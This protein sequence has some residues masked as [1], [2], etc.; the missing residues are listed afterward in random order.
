MIPEQAQDIRDMGIHADTYGT[1]R[2]FIAIDP[3]AKNWKNLLPRIIAHEYHHSIWIS[4]NFETVHFSLLDCLIL[5]GRAEGF[6]DIIYP[7][8]KA[9]WPDLTREEEYRVW[10]YM[11][12]VLYSTD[13]LLIMKMITGNKEIPFLSVYSM[14]YKIM[15]DFLENNHQIS[16]TE[17]TNY[18]PE[19]ILLKSR[20]EN[21]FE[22]N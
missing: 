21:K 15:Q 1:G 5:E 18:K 7:D 11:K 19:E 14:G 2:I 6:A 20:Y 4:R 3:A 12:P 16:L 17:W 22:N 9:P 10:N 8:I 13:E